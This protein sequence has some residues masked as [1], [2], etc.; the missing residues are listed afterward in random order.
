[1]DDEESLKQPLPMV[2]DDLKRPNAYEL[3]LRQSRK[4]GEAATRTL[5]VTKE[6]LKQDV[7]TLR[8]DQLLTPVRVNR[9]PKVP[10]RDKLQQ[11]VSQSREVLAEGKTVIL[12]VNLFPDTVIVDRTKVTIIKKSFFWSSQVISVRIEDVLN[13]STSIGPFFGSLTI[14]SRVMNSTDHFEINYFWRNDAVRLKCMIQ[15]Y[16]IAQ[17]NNIETSHLSKQE[18]IET[19]EELGRDSN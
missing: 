4:M 13:V 12:P 2:D 15:G 5:D 17:H 19:L 10:S 6:F 1:M 9:M 3:L 7:S 18:L 8:P 16:M 14:S 11:I